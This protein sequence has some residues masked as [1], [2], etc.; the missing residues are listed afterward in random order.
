MDVLHYLW[1]L[2]ITVYNIMI[3]QHKVFPFPRSE[4]DILIIIS[5]TLILARDQHFPGLIDN[6]P[7]SF[8]LHT[9]EAKIAKR[10]QKMDVRVL[11][12]HHPA[13]EV[14][15]GYHT[16]HIVKTTNNVI[17]RSFIAGHPLKIIA[18]LNIART[19]VVSGIGQAITFNFIIISHLN[20][21]TIG[22]KS[23][24]DES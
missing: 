16:I 20:I 1:K 5:A 17:P 13:V 6:A 7:A 19:T 21:L 22:G 24:C 10:P 3:S 15:T 12:F 8:F 14:R 4:C 2:E 9:K 11:A 23:Q 18:Q